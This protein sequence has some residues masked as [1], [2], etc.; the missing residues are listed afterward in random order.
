M[1]VRDDSD[2]DFG[3]YVEFVILCIVIYWVYYGFNIK[4]VNFFI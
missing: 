1:V 3:N 2:F 4:M